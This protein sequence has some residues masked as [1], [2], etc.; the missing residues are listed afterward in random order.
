[1]LA[2]YLAS[3]LYDRM[4]GEFKET[5]HAL[6]NG[7][8]DTDWIKEWIDEHFPTLTNDQQVE[9]FE[10]LVYLIDLDFGE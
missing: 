4:D 3:A 6:V 1:M 10:H 5:V 7:N 2:Q 9:I 8:E